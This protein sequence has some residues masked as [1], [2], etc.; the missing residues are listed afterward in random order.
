[1]ENS[2]LQTLKAEQEAAIKRLNDIAEEKNGYKL[3]YDTVKMEYDAQKLVVDQNARALKAFE[4]RKARQ[5]KQ[6]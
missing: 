3:K 1:M 6:A 4:P 2:L 5:K